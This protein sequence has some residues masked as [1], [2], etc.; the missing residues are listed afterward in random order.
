MDEATAWPFGR[1]VVAVVAA[2]Y[3]AAG[4]ILL[5]QVGPWEVVRQVVINGMIVAAWLW[6]AARILRDT[7]VPEETP[8]RHPRGELAWL[9]VVLVVAIGLAANGYGR[10]LDLPS[11][12]LQAV[13]YGGVL[14]MVIG[15]RYPLRDL[16]T[17]W[18][19]RRAWGA[20]AAAILIN[21]AAAVLFQIVP[22][23]EPLA[24]SPGDLAQEITGPLSVVV[25]IVG[26]L[27]RAALPEE[28]LLR[29]TMQPRLAR[30]VPL[31]WAIVIQALLFNIAHLPQRLVGY[32][33]PAILAL[34]YT[35]AIDN[36]LIAGYLWYR[37]RSLPLLAVLHLFAFPR[38]GI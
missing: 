38:F 15:L 30:V 2:L 37:T 31:G 26:L 19:S 34:A 18:P 14:L 28:L 4:A 36:G 17:R 13:M 25:L 6:S 33:E 8:I 35:M 21:V 20:L 7:P 27:F 9:V 12:L 22:R 3:V 10:W 16:G 1:G 29:V 5:V 24:S 11:W 23:D 32:D